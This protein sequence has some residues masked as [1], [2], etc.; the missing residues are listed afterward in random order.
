MK[1][2]S[3]SI[4]AIF[5]SLMLL[6]V[7]SADDCTG[8]GTAT[9]QQNRAQ[10]QLT[11]E[12]VAQVGMPNIHNFREKRLLKQIYEM[13]DQEGLVTYTY[14]Q[15][16]NGH[17]HFFCDSFGYPLPAATQYTAPERPA[18][19]YETYEQG[20][21]TIPQEDPNGLFSPA[22]AEGSWV[23]CKDPHSNKAGVVYSEPR[24]ITTPF[25]METK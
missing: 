13:R 23:V 18:K 4:G 5:G 21:V 8:V 16:L 17:L 10:A 19:S 2:V 14:V 12:G 24:L 9:T 15:D 22:D 7:C 3:K 11:A 6:I 20:N 25:P 1:P